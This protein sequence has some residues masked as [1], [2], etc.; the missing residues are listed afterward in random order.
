MSVRVR[1]GA[2]LACVSMTAQG[3]ASTAVRRPIIAPASQPASEPSSEPTSIPTVPGPVTF[4]RDGFNRM[5]ATLVEH[6]RQQNLK[7][8]DL[9]KR[10]TIKTADDD[11]AQAVVD[12]QALE[13]KLWEILGP[14]GAVALSV[15]VGLFAH[16][17]AH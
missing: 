16:Y 15:A 2:A 17:V 13:L 10:L 4:T 12:Q 3:C 6:N 1:L 14:V 7:I 5:A 11:A 8:A 9:N